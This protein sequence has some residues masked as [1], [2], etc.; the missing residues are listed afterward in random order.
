M[1]QPYKFHTATANDLLE[2]GN[3]RYGGG[4]KKTCTCDR[5]VGLGVFNGMRCDVCN[6]KGSVENKP[7]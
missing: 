1:S 2:R 3:Q 4:A 5:C 7:E 6:G